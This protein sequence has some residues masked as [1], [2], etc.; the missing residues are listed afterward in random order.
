M[1]LVVKI[2]LFPGGKMPT[3]GT[4]G[5]AAWDCYARADAEVGYLPTQ[6]GLGFALELP[7]GYHAEV[8][9][10][11]STGYRTYLRMPNSTGVI[12]SDYRGEVMALY[13]RRAVFNKGGGLQLKP[14]KIKAGE[15]IAQLL[16]VKDPEVQLQQAEELTETG[17]GGG[18]F[19][20]TGA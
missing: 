13:E 18:G 12:D 16:I 15:R 8:L 14:E 1:S 7:P 6:I 5:A 11:S 10:R 20:S 19:G 3:K 2:K 4:D 9:P 17:R